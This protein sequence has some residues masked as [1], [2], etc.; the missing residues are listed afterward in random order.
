MKHLLRLT[1]LVG[2]LSLLAIGCR[3]STSGSSGSG[4]TAP[5]AK[6]DNAKPEGDLAT[7]TLS[8]EAAKHLA[9]QTKKVTIEPVAL[10]R[11]VGGEAIVPPGKSAVVAAPV[12]GV[13]TAGR[14]A[15]IG[16]VR[17]GDVIFE[18]APLQQSERD[19][20]AE[21][22]RAVQ[23]AEARLTQTTQRAQ[24]LEQLLKEGSASERAVEDARADR[25]VAAAA[26]EAARKRLE[27]VSRLAVGP[28]GELTLTA[29]FDGFLIEL[30]AAGGQ[31]VTAG[32]IV[33]DVVQTSALWIRAPIYVGD[34]SSLDTSQ[35]AMVAALGQETTGPWRQARRVMGPPGANPAAASV[36]LFFEV[37]F[38]KER[39]IRPGE[40]LAVRVPLKATDRALVVPQSAVIYDVNGGTWVYEER[41]PHKFARR[42][43]ELGG[44][45]GANV[46]I[47]R[48]LAEGVTIVTVGAAELYG[49]EFY[50]SK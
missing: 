5:A 9:I 19:V 34:L 31:T 44:P 33:A 42:R 22:E 7:V 29:P 35:P 39:P 17:R 32:T 4:K 48:G 13:L 37:P 21:A 49:T 25:A 8:P 15:A 47:A 18:L 28:R 43:V 26:A 50:V 40:R 30:R 1:P 10:S 14:A 16:P 36:D 20:R 11:T 12:A 46:I 2:C 24:R 45:A 27:A 41:A 6:V 23:E 3:G 38:D